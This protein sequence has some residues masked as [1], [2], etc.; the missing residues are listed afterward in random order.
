MEE[1]ALEDLEDSPEEPDGSDDGE[2]HL[3]DSASSA[4]ED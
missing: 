3:E 4:E 1:G 2:N